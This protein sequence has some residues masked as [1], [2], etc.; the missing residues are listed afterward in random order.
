[1]ADLSKLDDTELVK[2]CLTGDRSLFEEVVH[3][4]Q[5][6]IY[7]LCLR[8]VADLGQAQDIVQETFVVGYENLARLKDPS[9]LKPWLMG[10]ASNLIRDYYKRRKL[11]GLPEGHDVEV[12]GLDPL[13][14]IEQRE[15]H[16]L[17]YRAI[18]RLSERYKA[19]LIKRYLEEAEYPEIA[20]ELGLSVGAV[21]V[22]MHRARKALAAAMKELTPDF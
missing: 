10:I 4:Y 7:G 8:K 13:E 6:N 21:E 1:M 5:N 12:I 11:A 22:C 18:A 19:V 14:S 20:A 9:R 15:R 16:E 3:R 2:R 17:L